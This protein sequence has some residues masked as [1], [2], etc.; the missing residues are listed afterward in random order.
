[1]SRTRT[2]HR[3]SLFLILTLYVLFYCFNASLVE[4][5]SSPVIVAEP[6]PAADKMF[7]RDHQWLGGDGA[8]SIDLGGGGV[9]WLFGDSFIDVRDRHLRGESVLIRN[10]VAIQLGHDPLSATIR[11]Y[12]KIKDNVP[13]AF[14]PGEE[15][16]WF[17]PGQGVVTNGF[18]LLFLLQMHPSG[19]DLGFE[20]EGWKVLRVFNFEDEPGKWDMQW[21]HTPGNF[22]GII[23]GS[24]G[25]LLADGYLYAYG[26]DKSKP[27]DVFLAR[28]PVAE[29]AQGDLKNP[30]WWTGPLGGWCEQGKFRGKPATIFANGQT[31][32][33]VHYEPMLKKFIQIQTTGF[34]SADIAFR[35]SKNLLGPWSGLKQLYRPKEYGEKGIFMYAGKAHPEQSGSDMIITY[36]VNH[37]D[38][39]RILNDT[40]IYYP[41]FLKCR[42]IGGDAR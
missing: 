30:R 37:L 36:V 2:V 24:G 23:I 6:W 31:E 14:F 32:F 13:Q 5:V 9:L 41:K 42:I 19:N 18:L 38:P 12:W 34:G 40:T 22:Y 33:T 17:W 4:G 26:P 1:M 27:H 3:K 39:Q 11:F 21:A 28:W 25:V 7:K 15:T 20:F 35:T 8:S 16:S 29:V 10:S